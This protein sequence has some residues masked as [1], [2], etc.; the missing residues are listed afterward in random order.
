MTLGPR[1]PAFLELNLCSTGPER[2]S[3]AVVLCTGVD[4]LLLE[5]RKLILERAGHIVIEA[6]NA[7]EATAVCSKQHVDIV[8]LCQTLLPEGKREMVLAV[9]Q[10]CPASKILELYQSHHGKVLHDADEWMEVPPAV[11]QDL[12]KCVANLHRHEPRIY[13]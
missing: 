8:L 12:A 13:R 2:I 4:P 3:V 9:R 1:H 11:P 7:R 5:T 10:Y 6:T